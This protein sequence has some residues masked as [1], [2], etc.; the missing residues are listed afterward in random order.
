MEN[1]Q[2]ALGNET[3]AISLRMKVKTIRGDR[4]MLLT[5]SRSSFLLEAE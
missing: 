3:K 1:H 5:L 2:C 4:L